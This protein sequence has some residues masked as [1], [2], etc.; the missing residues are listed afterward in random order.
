MQEQKHS[1]TLN[2]VLM[3]E[4]TLKNAEE[5]ITLAELKRR[6]PSKIMHSTLITILNY[7]QLSGKIIIG[8]KGI[9]WVFVDRRE[10][11]RLIEKGIEI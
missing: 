7:L 4:R 9:L 1:P 3:V 5:V 6:L 11:N 8:I 10:L 2:T